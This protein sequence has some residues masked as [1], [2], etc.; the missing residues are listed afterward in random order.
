M[1][2]MGSASNKLKNLICELSEN[3]LIIM[4]L[5]SLPEESGK[6]KINYNS[7]KEKWHSL[8]YAI[9]FCTRRKGL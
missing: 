3:L 4:I 7:M 5:D 9:G 8:R 2:K 6:F 1:L